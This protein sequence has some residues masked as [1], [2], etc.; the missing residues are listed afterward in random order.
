MTLYEQY[1]KD[2]DE[3][4]AFYYPGMTERTKMVIHHNTL[5]LSAMRDALTIEQGGAEI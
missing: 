1:T 3:G 2:I 5:I 4:E